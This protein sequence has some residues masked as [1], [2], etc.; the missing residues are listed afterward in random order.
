[1]KRKSARNPNGAK[2]ELFFDGR[3]GWCRAGARRLEWLDWLD[4][5]ELRDYHEIPPAHRPAPFEVFDRGMPVRTRGGRL[6]IGFDGVR[7]ALAHT[8]LGLPAALILYLPGISL[9]GRLVYGWIARRRPG[10]R[11]R[12]D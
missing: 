2:V 9:I 6:L 7:H 12:V 10:R 8:P 11:C 4:R 3:C 5:L 1:M